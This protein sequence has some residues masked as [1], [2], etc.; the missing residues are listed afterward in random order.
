[1]T[2]Q[3]K[4]LFDT[5]VTLP[6]NL[7]DGIYTARLFLT[8][9]GVVVSQSSETIYV[10]KVGLEKLLYDLAHDQP[11][12]YGILSLVIA[13]AAGWGASAAFRYFQS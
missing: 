7:V 9:G 5:S 8:K 13:I 3:E 10:E 1:M 6:A 11:W 4:T 2:V 12:L